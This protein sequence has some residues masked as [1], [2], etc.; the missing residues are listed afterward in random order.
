MTQIAA[1]ADFIETDIT[2]DHMM[3][4][5]YLFNA[6]A[7]NHQTMEWMV[8]ARIWLDQ[9]GAS[10]YEL[11]FRKM[12]DKCKQVDT[13]FVLGKTLLGVVTDWSD[14]ENVLHHPQT[15]TWSTESS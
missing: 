12:F 10:A 2:Y 13:A 5:K 9:Q 15:N 1:K 6:V 7:F 4:Y 3:E 8:I 14:S 11:A